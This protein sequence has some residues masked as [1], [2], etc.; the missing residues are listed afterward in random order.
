MS[1][2]RLFAGIGVAALLLGLVFQAGPAEALRQEPSGPTP[3]AVSD[4][5]EPWPPVVV[6]MRGTRTGDMATFVML[7]VNR[8]P[9]TYSYELK[10]RL[11][12]NSTLVFCHYGTHRT[13]WRR[14][15]LDGQGNIGWNN[16]V[17]V[18]G[19]RIVGP[20]TF[21]VQ[22]TGDGPVTS[23]AWI[24][25]Y[26]NSPAGQWTG[27]LVWAGG[28][29][30]SATLTGAAQRPGPGDPRGS[31]SAVISINPDQGRVCFDLTV[32]G[33]DPPIASHIHRGGPEVAGPVVVPL[34]AP[35]T[36]RSVGCVDGISTELL[37]DIAT[38]PGNYYVNVH[39]RAY[40]DGAVR[41]QLMMAH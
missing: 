28:V 33:I 8:S 23:Y 35:T 4:Q 5:P 12:E 2:R 40:P 38:N 16:R 29:T 41:G 18:A 6:Q 26:N 13:D 30:L 31:G 9:R 34:P 22:V 25:F 39:T 19:G 37:T 1:F 36:G 15:G 10:A 17:G 21:T 11:P 20:Y 7:V 3:A 32:Q 14:C 27:P 24:N